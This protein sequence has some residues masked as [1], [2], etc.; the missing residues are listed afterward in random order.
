[1]RSVLRPSTNSPTTCIFR[2]AQS[3]GGMRRGLR[4]ALLGVTS[5]LVL[6]GC[7][8]A[9]PGL[10]SEN[11]GAGLKY[12]PGAHAPTVDVPHTVVTPGEA[13]GVEELIADGES[14]LERREPRRALASFARVIAVGPDEPWLERAHFGAATAHDLLGNHREA[15][16][17]YQRVASSGRSDARVR[18]AAVR[19]VRLRVHLEQYSEAGE[20]A[21]QVL[22]RFDDLRPLE[23]V[24]LYGAKALELTARGEDDG[25]MRWVA[26]GQNLVDAHG[27]DAPG[28]I[29]RDLSQLYFA[30]GEVRRL[31]A[32]RI[33]FDPVPSDFPQVL[34]QR[35]Q[36]LLDAQSAYSDAM[37]AYDAHWSAMAG[38]RI[39]ELYQRLHE[40]LMRVPAPEVAS[41]QEQRDLFEGAMRLRYSI[42]LSKAA[43]MMKHTRVMVERTGEKSRWA[44]KATRAQQAIEDA[45]RREEEAL[46]RLPY[47]RHQLQDALDRLEDRYADGAPPGRSPEASS[48]PAG[49]FEPVILDR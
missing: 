37:R 5:G 40:D 13:V 34:E 39:G 12:P 17:G 48:G 8:S 14:A 49:T 30:L 31:R 44:E 3:R 21:G 22:S 46:E 4:L 32:E 45:L 11:E 7:A 43:T 41:K 47:T 15:L 16:S 26:R 35:C 20:A 9:S 23:N 27:F 24:A 10:G 33:D 38:F 19:A 42:L 2:G 28:P 36:L 6:V 29:P 18:I 1:M 25:A